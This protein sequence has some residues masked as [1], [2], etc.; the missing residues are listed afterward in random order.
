MSDG[1]SE[2]EITLY[3]NLTRFANSKEQYD[4]FESLETCLE[5]VGAFLRTNK[6]TDFDKAIDCMNHTLEIIH[7]LALE[8]KIMEQGVIDIIHDF[9]LL[10]MYILEYTAEKN[11]VTGKRLK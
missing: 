2:K 10:P 7:I 4:M 11:E 9:M 8:G 3:P 6:K 5:Q 1:D